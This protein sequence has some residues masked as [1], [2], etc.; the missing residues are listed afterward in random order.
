[1]E[2][3]KLRSVIAAVKYGGVSEASYELYTTQSTVTKNIKAVENE[4]GIKLFEKS[5]RRLVLT[6]AGKK[7][8]PY[9]EKVVTDYDSLDNQASKIAHKYVNK[10]IINSTPIRSGLSVLDMIK[11]FKAAYPDIQL[12]IIENSHTSEISKDLDVG[13]IDVAVIVQTY[14][15][16]YICE[17]GYSFV[18]KKYELQ[19]LLKDYFFVVIH[20]NH[21]LAGKDEVS[22]LDLQAEPFIS[23]S[24]KFEQY[25]SMLNKVSQM[26][27]MEFNIVSYVDSI[28]SV[29]DMVSSGLGVSI[30]SSRVLIPQ[31]D[32]L[33]K[34]LKEDLYR[35]TAV[36]INSR[37]KTVPQLQWFIDY[38]R[39][40]LEVTSKLPQSD[41][42]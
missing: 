24:E 9:I 25:H 34:P 35:F 27:D 13:A 29:L 21:P 8:F 20:K 23:V 33:I 17:S 40:N 3:N 16:S 6:Q 5:G 15:S 2:I 26:F 30:L 12:E 36:V 31:K 7:I 1:M 22:L 4:L 18:S 41:M 38:A 42:Q 11:A 32:I 39:S 14:V 37:S 28:S 10:I 19:P